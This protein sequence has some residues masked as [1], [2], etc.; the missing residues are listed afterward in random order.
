[1]MVQY[2]NWL[3]RQQW[4]GKQRCRGEQIC[5]QTHPK[6]MSE[7]VTKHLSSEWDI[8]TE[9]YTMYLYVASTCL[10]ET[11]RAAPKIIILMM[12]THSI[13]GGCWWY[14]S[15]GWTF[16]PISH[17]IL[18]PCDRWQQRRSL[19]EWHLTWKCVRSKCVELNSL[20][21]KK[22][23]TL[24]FINTCW[25]FLETKQWMWA[26]WGEVV[27]FSS[28]DSGPSLV[29][30]GMTTVCRLLFITGKIV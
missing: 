17:S 2:L 12:L 28:G 24:T 22:W 6:R 8:Y 20:M 13:R 29:Q 7:N 27:F 4:E 1:M 18:L 5:S 26:Q 30:I 25:T 11:A 21:R 14:G 3:A 19:T 15:R 23:C 9:I 16:L 10:S